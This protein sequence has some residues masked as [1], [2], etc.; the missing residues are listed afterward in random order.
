MME[1][2]VRQA[3]FVV[4]ALLFSALAGAYYLYVMPLQDQQTSLQVRLEKMKQ[5]FEQLQNPA[6]AK[7]QRISPQLLSQIQEAI[8]VKPYADQLIK[9][10]DRLQSISQVSIEEATFTEQEKLSAKDLADQLA[11][12]DKQEKEGEK[13]DGADAGADE[14]AKDDEASQD[15]KA[16]DASANVDEPGRQANDSA[17]AS[18]S[19]V[20]NAERQVKAEIIEKFLPEVHFNSISISMKIKGDYEQIY[21]FVTEMQKLSRYLRVDQLDFK[22]NQKDEFV[23]PKETRMTAT[24]KL[25]SYFAPQFEKYVDKLPVVQVEGASGKWNPMEYDIT[26]KEDA[27]Q[28]AS[29]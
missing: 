6:A 2:R 14:K 5:S 4:F 23:I 20:L 18:G 16:A 27:P 19:A 1:G 26:K 8:P 9:D 12:T 13:K 21:R 17:Q 15:E 22:T 10:L 24:V 28:A 7:E 3:A 29:E 11:Y 25:T